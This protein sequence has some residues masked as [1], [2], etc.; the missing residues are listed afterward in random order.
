MEDILRAA[1][2][3]AI[4]FVGLFVFLWVGCLAKKYH[5]EGEEHLWGND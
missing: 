1:F 2:L 5:V 4:V 3:M